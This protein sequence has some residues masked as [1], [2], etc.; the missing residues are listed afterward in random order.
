MTT[1]EECI[2]EDYARD[3]IAAFGTGRYFA[4]PLPTAVLTHI[5]VMLEVNGVEVMI[6]YYSLSGHPYYRGE[7]LNAMHS[8]WQEYR[9]L[10]NFVIDHAFVD[11][12]RTIAAADAAL[13]GD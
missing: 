4:E 9:E 10:Y 12:V 8:K 7:E 3:I 2:C 6:R 13:W 11:H 1:L 5:I